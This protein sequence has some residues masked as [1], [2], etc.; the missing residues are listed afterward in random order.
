MY[1]LLAKP[2]KGSGE[3]PFRPNVLM[4]HLD[5][6]FLGFFTKKTRFSFID[7]EETKSIKQKQQFGSTL[8]MIRRTSEGTRL[9]QQPS[10]MSSTGRTLQHTL[11]LEI[12]IVVNVCTCKSRKR[13]NVNRTKLIPQCPPLSSN[14]M[15]TIRRLLMSPTC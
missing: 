14:I 2:R 12:V 8:L 15:R 6:E 9:Q 4:L 13:L 5:P 7:F 1:F 11:I 10:S 3:P